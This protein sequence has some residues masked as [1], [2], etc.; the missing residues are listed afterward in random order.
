[1]WINSGFFQSAKIGYGTTVDLKKLLLPQG[2]ITGS[3]VVQSG[4]KILGLN[5]V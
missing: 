1:M 5:S 4:W 3:V 2:D